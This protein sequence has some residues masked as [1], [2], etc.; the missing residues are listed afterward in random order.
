MIHTRLA[1]A[2]LALTLFGCGG[3]SSAPPTPTAVETTLNLDLQNLANYAAP[4]LPLYYDASVLAT[5]NTPGTDPVDDKIA[6]LGRVL[7]YDT[8]LSVNNAI[9]CAG[10]HLQAQGFGDVNR[11]SL[12]F[13][14]AAF[15]DAHAMR[16]GNLRFFKSGRMFWNQRAA[17]VEEQASQPIQHPVEMGFDSTAGGLSALFT[18]MRTLG[19]ARW[20]TCSEAVDNP[21]RTI[22]P[23]RLH[24]QAHSVGHNAFHRRINPSIAWISDR[25]DASSLRRSMIFWTAE[26]TVVWCLP[27]NA[28]AR[29]G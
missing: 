29:S 8:K 14:G 17:S 11:F 24:S 15:T 27:P 6:T 1:I 2:S 5:D 25:R 21:S 9:S 10:C 26:I 19:V 28:R 23:P 4:A 22:H 7:F 16:L 3:G 13:S 18:K 20:M 12:G